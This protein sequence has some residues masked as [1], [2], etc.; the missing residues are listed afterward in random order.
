[1]SKKLD[2]STYTQKV[3]LRRE[4]IERFDDDVKPVVMETH[5]GA[6]KLYDAVYA[7]FKQGVVFEK[8]PEKAGILAIQRPTWAVYECDSTAALSEGV[9]SHLC[10]DLLDVDPWGDSW[11]TIKAFFSSARPFAERMVVVVNCGL[12]QKLRINGAWLTGSMRSMVEKYGNDL[13]PV[14]LDLVCP[15]LLSEYAGR[16]GYFLDDFLG[17]YCG[18]SL[19]ITHFLAVLQKN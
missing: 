15:E 19:Q 7:G 16:V 18:A 11:P 17:Y 10:I 4:A 9:G 1:V 2:N 5:G 13:H 8:D 6:G 14:Y 3:A 12:R